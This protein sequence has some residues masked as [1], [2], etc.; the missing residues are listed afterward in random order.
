[1]HYKSSKNTHSTIISILQLHA[2]VRSDRSL[3]RLELNGT[4]FP[5]LWT[6]ENE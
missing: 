5:L 3:T 4:H 2:K 1:M 6:R